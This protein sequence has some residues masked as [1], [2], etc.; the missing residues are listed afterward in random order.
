[1]RRPHSGVLDTITQIPSVETVLW[2]MGP[3]RVAAILDNGQAARLGEGLW[4]VEIPNLLNPVWS[5]EYG[6][7]KFRALR[8]SA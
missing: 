5:R 6:L 8:T 7:Y 1:M 3:F 4:T 2:T